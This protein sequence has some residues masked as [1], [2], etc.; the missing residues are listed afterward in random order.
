MNITKVAN[1]ILYMI[2]NEVSYLNDKK[3]SI[4]LFLMDYESTEKSGTKIFDEE[5]IKTPRN[6][7]PKLLTDLFEVMAND[8]ELED[9][10]F[11][12]D[13][14]SELLSFVEIEIVEKSNFIEL[15]FS[16]FEEDFDSSVFNKDEMNIIKD[17]TTKYQTISPRNI[18]NECFKIEKL[19]Q[20]PKDEIII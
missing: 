19:R 3:L 6:P 14:I 8:E 9:D 16:K 15:K 4:M 1:A 20:T 7:E 5:Y 18:A 11:R 17:I 13:F 12:L 2:E 10:D